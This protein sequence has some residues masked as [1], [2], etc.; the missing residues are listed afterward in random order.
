M[1]E[2]VRTQVF[3][4]LGAAGNPRIRCAREME[5]FRADAEGDPCAAICGAII[6]THVRQIEAHLPYFQRR[7]TFVQLSIEQIHLRMANESANKSV[8][9]AMIDIGGSANLLE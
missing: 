8:D 1:N 2:V 7:S 9:R 5:I 4:K 6:Q 3:D